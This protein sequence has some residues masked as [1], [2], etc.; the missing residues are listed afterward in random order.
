MTLEA[1][2]Q[3]RS[4]YDSRFMHQELGFNAV[5]S[6]GL[7]QGLN[8]VSKQPLLDLMPV[9]RPASIGHE[10]IADHAFATFVNKE[11]IA[12][13]AATLNRG[14]SGEDLGVHVAQDHIRRAAVVPREQSRPRPSLI[15]QKGTQVDRRKVPQVEN[16]HGIPVAD[17]S[18]VL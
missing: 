5:D 14:I 11:R 6:G 8:H 13:N 16:L 1:L 3:K 17:A 15:F 2:F 12:E 10:Q 7:L 4:G 18:R 9:R